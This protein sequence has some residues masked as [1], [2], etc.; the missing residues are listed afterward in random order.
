MKSINQAFDKSEELISSTH[1]RRV[2]IDITDCASPEEYQILCQML[3]N[4]NSAI[5]L[6]ACSKKCRNCY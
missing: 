2:D 3:N 6:S 1:N 4:T 5:D